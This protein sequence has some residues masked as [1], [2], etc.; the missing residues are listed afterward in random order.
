MNA[1][2]FELYLAD[3]NDLIINR[4]LENNLLTVQSIDG[5][6]MMQRCLR[7]NTKYT[8]EISDKGILTFNLETAELTK[9]N[10][11][12]TKTYILSMLVV[13]PNYNKQWFDFMTLALQN[14]TQAREYFR[15]LQKDYPQYRLSL[16]CV[17]ETILEE[18]E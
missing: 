18:S 10:K 5:M 16:R 11:N 4:R 14:E 3:G 9:T 12:N 2:L 15:E 13:A 7:S 1:K 6:V 17:E 8:L